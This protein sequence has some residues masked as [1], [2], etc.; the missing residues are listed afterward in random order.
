MFFPLVWL[1][2]GR[3]NNLEKH[4]HH[5]FVGKIC[6]DI[7]SC[8]KDYKWYISGIYCQL[9]DYISPIPPKKGNQKQLLIM[10]VATG[11]A[12]RKS[13]TL[14]SWR[15]HV[16]SLCL[17]V[18]KLPTIWRWDCIGGPETGG[19]R[20]KQKRRELMSWMY[21]KS[22][23]RREVRSDPQVSKHILVGI[24]APGKPVAVIF[25]STLPLKPAQLPRKL[26]H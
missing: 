22:L 9:G 26:V 19:K 7:P 18:V 16:V 23:H 25:P 10:A 21:L 4:P 6:Q 11:W 20:G 2:I 13:W 8:G 12:M 14:Q 1:R 24:L 5:V 17:L 3:P 15:V